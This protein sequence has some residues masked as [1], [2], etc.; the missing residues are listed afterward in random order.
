MSKTHHT[1]LV[2]VT[3]DKAAPPRQAARIIGHIL[4]G[5]TLEDAILEANLEFK[6][7][8]TPILYSAH[9]VSSGL[10]QPVAEHTIIPDQ[11]E[12][13]AA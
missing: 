4:A 8:A 6:N 3:F 10:M 9:P 12:E 5:K 2:S 13:D 1:L 7:T 11:Q